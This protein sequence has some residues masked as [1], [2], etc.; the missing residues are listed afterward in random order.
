MFNRKIKWL[1]IGIGC[2]VGGMVW[3]IWQ[4]ATAIPPELLSIVARVCM[5]K[6]MFGQAS[7][8]DAFMHGAGQDLTKST[9]PIMF[10]PVAMLSSV[11]FSLLSPYKRLLLWFAIAAVYSISALALFETRQLIIP[12]GGPLV[13]I[14]FCYLCGTLIGLESEKITR[15]REL[16]T[17]MQIQSEEERKRIAKDLHD[18]VLPSLSRVMRLADQLQEENAEST[19]P[20][21]MRT[22]LES[23]VMEMRR[24]INDL[25]P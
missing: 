13:L 22:R 19:L 23:T 2:L 24:V 10:L 20:A 16:A 11:V 15:S 8:A 5:S 21:E 14:T 3:F 17:E 1:N 9:N 18:E 7:A 12:Y 25:H 6:L 4:A